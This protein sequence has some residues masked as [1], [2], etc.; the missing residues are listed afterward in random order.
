MEKTE[1]PQNDREL[2]RNLDRYEFVRQQ[3]PDRKWDSVVHFTPVFN[4]TTKKPVLTDNLEP[5]LNPIEWSDF[6]GRPS[7]IVEI[8]IGSGKGGFLLEYAMK[9]PDRC[10]MGSEWD[11]TWAV[12]AGERLAKHHVK[13]AKMLRGDVYYWLRDRV[14][15]NTVD[16]FHMY[17]PDPWPKKR[18]QKNRLMRREFLE[19]VA[20]VLKPGKRPF[21]WGTDHQEYNEVAQELFASFPNL[22]VIQKDSADP[23]DGIMT[24]FE[25]KYRIE[26]RPI[27]RSILEFTK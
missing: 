23:T 24:N 6:F 27:Y 16:A 25:K 10:I 9:H 14:K 3:V 20:R 11:A 8:E 26:G 1:I 19:Q 22:K 7:P 17:F 18:Q 12:Y 13:N 21:F 4:E 5:D 2:P 15:E